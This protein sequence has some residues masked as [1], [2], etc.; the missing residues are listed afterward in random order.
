[1]PFSRPL[2]RKCARR[3]LGEN[4]PQAR[5]EALA[6]AR[7]EL[8]KKQQEGTEKA[9]RVTAH[10]EHRL[11]KEAK[12]AAKQAAASRIVISSGE[13]EEQK[14]ADGSAAVLQIASG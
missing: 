3:A 10:V 2:F 6:K 8:A 9:N 13:G 7:L 4:R 12:R 5:A 1:M 11:A 14:N